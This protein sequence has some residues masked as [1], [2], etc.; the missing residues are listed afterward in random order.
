MTLRIYLRVLAGLLGLFAI[1]AVVGC[2]ENIVVA[3]KPAEADPQ[4]ILER[5]AKSDSYPD[6]YVFRDKVNGKLIYAVP[7]CGIAVEDK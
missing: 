2:N 1:L 3:P 6:I 7:G 5:K 4:F